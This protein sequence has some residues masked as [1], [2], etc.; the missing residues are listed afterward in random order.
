MTAFHFRRHF[1]K[2]RHPNDPESHVV[3]PS[4]KEMVTDPILHERIL[5]IREVK[6]FVLLLLGTEAHK[7]MPWFPYSKEIRN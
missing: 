5:A 7:S 6:E 2:H 3:L 1:T 4:E